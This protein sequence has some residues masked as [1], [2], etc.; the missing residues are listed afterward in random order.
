MADGRTHF[1]ILEEKAKLIYQEELAERERIENSDELTDE[2][3]FMK[4]LADRAKRKKG[5][6]VLIRKNNETNQKHTKSKTSSR[7]TRRGNR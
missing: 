5:E 1:E 4:K 7:N 2:E 6:Q 3:L